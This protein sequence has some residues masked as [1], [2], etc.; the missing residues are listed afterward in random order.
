M[1][2]FDKT[3]QFSD[4][5]AITATAVST[6]VV[7]MGAMGTVKGN[8]AAM[9]QELAPG[10]GIPLL[11]QVTETFATLTSLAINIQSS[12][13]EAFTSPNTIQL[14]SIAA[15]DLVAGKR[16]PFHTPPEGLSGGYWRMQ[17][18]VTGSDA[19]AGKITAGVVAAVDAGK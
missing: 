10:S 19:T 13:D 6:N 16:T 18:V 1:T 5:Q 7:D 2:I 4:A 8:S 15:A 9:V 14:A 3:L 17:Y 12:A 11:V